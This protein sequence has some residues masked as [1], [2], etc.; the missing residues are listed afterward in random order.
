MRK[1][2]FFDRDG[3][4][5]NRL[6][7]DY[8]KTVEEFKFIEDFFLLFRFFKQKDYICVLVTN[9]QCIGKNII[10]CEEL[11][12]IHD[13]MQKELLNKTGFCFDHIYFSP[14]LANTGSKS[15]KPEPGMF[16]Q[17]IEDFNISTRESFTIGDSISDV[18]AG[19][20]VGTTTILVGNFQDISSADYILPDVA[21]VLPFFENLIK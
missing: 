13:F 16:L 17:A 10:S 6:I 18:E 2:V 21:S 7:D 1:A 5:N 12:E 11:L 14:D 9:Q 19:K 8:V 3:I 20:K 4:V 15:R